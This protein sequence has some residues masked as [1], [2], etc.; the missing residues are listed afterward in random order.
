[1]ADAEIDGSEAGFEAVEA[2]DGIDYALRTIQQTQVQF[3]L[4]ADSKAN[5]MITVCS[6]VI[7]VSLTQL[8]RPGLLLPLLT[9]DV[10]T[11][12]ALVAALLCVLP[13]RGATGRGEVAK[14]GSPSWNPLFFMYFQHL[15]L[16]EFEKELATRISPRSELY[17][18]LARDIYNQGVVLG[19]K[20][21][22]WLR[23]SY[24]SFMTG[25]LLSPVMGLLGLAAGI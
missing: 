16:P 20:K 21:Y 6:V 5:I 18:S 12:V 19:R 24:L 15:T 1:M 17:R 25:L 8:Q 22:R 13:S 7:T 23:L 9:L 2:R 10:F 4:M 14:P 11:A 3:S